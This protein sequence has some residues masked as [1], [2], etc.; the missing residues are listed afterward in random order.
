MLA[1]APRGHHTRALRRILATGLSRRYVDALLLAYAKTSAWRRARMRLPRIQCRRGCP[2]RPCRN[3]ALHALAASPRHPSG[4]SCHRHL[5]SGRLGQ[6]LERRR[7]DCARQW[8]WHGSQGQRGVHTQVCASSVSRRAERISGWTPSLA[9]QPAIVTR[10]DALMSFAGDHLRRAR[11][12]RRA[13][14]MALPGRTTGRSRG[15]RANASRR[16]GAR[17]A[18]RREEAASRAGLASASEAVSSPATS[19]TVPSRLVSSTGLRSPSILATLVSRSA[20]RSTRV[21]AAGHRCRRSLGLATPPGRGQGGAR[22]L[23]LTYEWVSGGRGDCGGRQGPAI[24]PSCRVVRRTHGVGTARS[25]PVDSHRIRL[26]RIRSGTSIVFSNSARPW[27]GYAL[28]G[29]SSTVTG[30]LRWAVLIAV[31][32]V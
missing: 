2:W 13:H 5:R 16:C 27:R 7:R 20:T 17:P 4:V 8:A 29:L 1:A 28:S 30:A 9:S 22:Q 6:R 3:I 19:S 24:R 32:G 12:A 25:E 18:R 21:A 26:R 10:A 15:C 31:H 11:L 14:A 23:K